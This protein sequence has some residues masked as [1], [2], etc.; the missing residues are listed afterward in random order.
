MGEEVKQITQLMGLHLSGNQCFI[1]L[2]FKQ[3]NGWLRQSVSSQLYQNL[4][5]KR[6]M[7]HISWITIRQLKW[8]LFSEKL[9]S[10]I[11]IYDWQK[12]TQLG[13]VYDKSIDWL[14]LKI[15]NRSDWKLICLLHEKNIIRPMMTTKDNQTWIYWNHVFITLNFSI[16]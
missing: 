7:N 6:K 13:A 4:Q 3:Q 2:Q 10:K 15:T 16:E 5:L 9:L 12:W 14:S 8:K 11:C 1:S